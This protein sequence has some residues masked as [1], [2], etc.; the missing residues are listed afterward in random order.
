LVITVTSDNPAVHAAFAALS[1]HPVLGPLIEQLDRSPYDVSIYDSPPVSTLEE[2]VGGRTFR[3][4][5]DPMQFLIEF[6]MDQARAYPG[7]CGVPPVESIE[8]VIAHELGH[9]YYQVFNPSGPFQ[10][11]PP[12]LDPAHI[13]E[14]NASALFFQNQFRNPYY[15][16]T[17]HQ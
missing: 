4:A 12:H 10:A 1:G 16:R 14:T 9:V 15:P 6:N 13:A 2:S 17:V 3:Y 7:A 8:E 11:N 5:D